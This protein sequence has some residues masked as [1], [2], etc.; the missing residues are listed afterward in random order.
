MAKAPVKSLFK[1]A[2]V[3]PHEEKPSSDTCVYVDGDSGHPLIFG[4]KLGG[5]EFNLKW[6]E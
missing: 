1:D 3:K 2:V 5:V 4:E 6:D